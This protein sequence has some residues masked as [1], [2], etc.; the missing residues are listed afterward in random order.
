MMFRLNTQKHCNFYFLLFDSGNI[1]ENRFVI[2]GTI[3]NLNNMNFSNVLHADGAFKIGS[4]F[5]LQ[6]YIIYYRIE[7]KVFPA[8]YCYLS[9]KYE[10]IYYRF[11][12]KIK[13]LTQDLLARYILFDMER[14]DI[15]SFKKFFENFSCNM[16]I[17]LGSACWRSI[18]TNEMSTDYKKMKSIRNSVRQLA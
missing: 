2:F 13:E 6:L 7:S 4:N 12:S 18:Q 11:F 16:F 10:N 15:N 3:E 8:V 14:A 5:F 1:D 9:K 17:Y